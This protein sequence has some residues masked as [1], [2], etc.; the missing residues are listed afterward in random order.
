MTSDPAERTGGETADTQVDEARQREL[1]CG[2]A[3]NPALPTLLVDRLIALKDPAVAGV[4][5]S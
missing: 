5:G 3:G 2:L 4:G 1:R